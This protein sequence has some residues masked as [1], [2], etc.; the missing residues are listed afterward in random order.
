MTI[1]RPFAKLLWFFFLLRN[2]EWIQRHFTFLPNVS[3]KCKTGQ[4]NRYWYCGEQ[5]GVYRGFVGVD[6]LIIPTE[7]K[8]GLKLCRLSVMESSVKFGN[9]RLEPWLDGS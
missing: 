2:S 9:Q 3:R 1:I 7:L 8:E 4:P 5:I 6:H